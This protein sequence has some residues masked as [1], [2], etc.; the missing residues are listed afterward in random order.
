MGMITNDWL[1]A[2]KEEFRKPYYAKLFGVEET[3][4]F[5]TNYCIPKGI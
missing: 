2:L 3:K 5:A 4:F 1:G